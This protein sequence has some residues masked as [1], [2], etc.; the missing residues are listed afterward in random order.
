MND[1]AKFQKQVNKEV[2]DIVKMV[3]KTKKKKEKSDG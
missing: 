3:N 1:L 2:Q